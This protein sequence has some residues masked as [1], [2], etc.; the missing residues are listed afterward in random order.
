MSATPKY[1]PEYGRADERPV[2]I[3]LGLHEVTLCD[4]DAG[5]RRQCH[6][7]IPSGC[8][9]DNFVGAA[10][11]RPKIA[12]SQ[13]NL[14]NG[15]HVQRQ[16]FPS[17][18]Q[19]LRRNLAGLGG[20]GDIAGGE[21][22]QRQRRI[23]QPFHEVTEFGRLLDSGRSDGACRGRVSAKCER[24]A[25]AD[26]PS[27]AEERVL[28]GV[29]IGDQRIELLNGSVEIATMHLRHAEVPAAVTRD[30]L[31]ADRLRDIASLRSIR[32]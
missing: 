6:G 21:G 22:G 4:R 8:R 27:E 30:E 18:A 31:I 12:A 13:R 10:S 32:R 15:I 26:S 25:M 14:G 20:G 11:S 16:E 9:A 19:S 24:H 17:L 23:A 2:C 28:A 5:A 3:L 1:A 29:G 7:S